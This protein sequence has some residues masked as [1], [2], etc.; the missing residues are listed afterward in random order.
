MSGV[1]SQPDKGWHVTTGWTLQARDGRTHRRPA[2]G[3]F[4]LLGP[5]G[6][7]NVGIVS[8]VGGP[9]DAPQRNALVHDAGDPRHVFRDPNTR[10]GGVDRLEF[11][12]DLGR[13][14]HLQ[15]VHVLVGWSTDHVDHD[16]CLAGIADSRLPLGCQ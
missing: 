2:T 5:A 16:H 6:I 4:I 11:T 10:N 14:I 12:P 3:R 7:A 15:V 9:M 8:A 1:R 13:G